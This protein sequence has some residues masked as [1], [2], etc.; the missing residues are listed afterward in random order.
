MG[1][2]KCI[3]LVTF[4]A[5]AMAQTYLS[6]CLPSGGTN[7]PGTYILTQDI[8]SGCFSTCIYV[9][10]TPANSSTVINMNGHK[11]TNACAGNPVWFDNVPNLILTTG[12]FV[13][14]QPG[15]QVYIGNSPNAQVQNM[16]S[17]GGTAWW[18]DRSPN[19]TMSVFY[20]EGNGILATKSP[21]IH[22]TGSQ[23]PDGTWNSSAVDF[24]SHS[25]GTQY[26][27]IDLRSSPGAS[28]DHVLIHCGLASDDGIVALQ[29]DLSA[30]NFNTSIHDVTI[31][32]CYDAAI[33]TGGPMA[34]LSIHDAVLADNNRG[35]GA[36]YDNSWYGA[37]IYNVAITQTYI[38]I[39][40]HFETLSSSSSFQPVF[41]NNTFNNITWDGRFSTL[42]SPASW[43]TPSSLM[44]FN[45]DFTS[46]KNT[47]RSLTPTMSGNSLTNVVLGVAG[48]GTILG[49][50]GLTPNGS[51][52]GS[53]VHCD[54]SY[55]NPPVPFTC[56]P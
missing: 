41:V 37:N 12:A 33:E 39:E 16:V 6:S 47:G 32:G 26:N 43:G 1:L 10:D 46:A 14:S 15:A 35:I 38:P 53:N 2:R 9:H 5:G 42:S 30:W 18:F 17:Q 52:T 56:L 23:N 34:F 50:L 51:W 29:E 40:L 4:A 28:V 36:W 11:I 25:T 55:P 8:T 44:H 31:W 45:A 54:P 13:N 27:G 19:S 48:T 24:Y 21:G 49:H 7:V 22:F 20:V 3:A